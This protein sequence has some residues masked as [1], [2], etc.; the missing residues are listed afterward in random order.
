MNKQNILFLFLNNEIRTGGHRRLL[1][2]CEDMAKRGHTVTGILNRDLDY[3]SKHFH[4]V[5]IT[6]PYIRNKG[7]SLSKRFS[8]A[9]AQMPADALPQ[10]IDT[11]MIHGE[12]HLRA[13]R[14]VLKRVPSSFIF[15]QRSNT[16]RE[17]LTILR[18]SEIGLLSK[19]RALTRIV[20]TR[21]YEAQITRCADRIL[22]QSTYDEQ[23]FITRNPK[24]IG[25]TRI[26]PGNIGLPRFIEK[27]ENTNT[28]SEC[29]RLLFVGTLGVRKGL[30]YLLKAF[31][32]LSKRGYCPASIIMAKSRIPS[33]ISSTQI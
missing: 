7:G 18:D 2:L 25:K 14:E 10:N 6:C 31:E 29:R 15:A 17:H 21:V 22:F 26:I 28:S 16:I 33:P 8:R 30:L 12:T 3:T 23:Y 32:I 9:I 20:V 11:L 19:L 5:Q 1:E 4:T 27:Y 13:A 24:A